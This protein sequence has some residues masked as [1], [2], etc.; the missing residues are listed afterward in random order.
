MSIV[1]GSVVWALPLVLVL[2]GCFEL[3]CGLGLIASGLALGAV[4][5]FLFLAWISRNVQL[6]QAKGEGMGGRRG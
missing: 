4:E 1:I 6:D 2:W 3:H 5:S